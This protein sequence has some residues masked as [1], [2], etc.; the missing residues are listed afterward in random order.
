MW[1]S[2][3]ITDGLSQPQRPQRFAAYDFHLPV[4][5]QAEERNSLERLVRNW[6]DFREQLLPLVGEEATNSLWERIHGVT[7]RNDAFD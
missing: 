6:D 1:S 2:L 3:L 7:E 5:L 4:R